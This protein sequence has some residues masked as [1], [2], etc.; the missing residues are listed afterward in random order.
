MAKKRLGKGLDAL[1]PELKEEQEN[2]KEPPQ[3]LPL[4]Q[5]RLNPQQPRKMISDQKLEELT[6]SV[7]IHGV[8]QPIIVKP[9]GDR[10]LIVAGER[11]YRA[12]KQAGLDTIP[13]VIKELSNSEVMQ[14][15]LLENIQREDLNPIDKGEAI[16]TLMEEHGLTQEQLSKQLGIGRSSLTNLIRL[17]QLEHEVREFLKN[18]QLSEG[19]ARALLSLEHRLQTSVAHEVINKQLSV[20]ETEKLV[21]RKLQPDEGK[22]APER[23]DPFIV[24]LE[25]QL[26]ESFGTK[27]SIKQGQ[28]KGKIEI[29]FIGNDDL[30]RLISLLSK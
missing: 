1:I 19:H 25:E 21:K 23:K 6:E 30:E 24:D 28:K 12:A 15:G 14:I 7:K 10:Y 11:R 26:T 17:L 16:K 29:E 9:Q 27:I 8:I 5:I 22:S 3:E 4:D 13:V 18:G 2:P 20:R